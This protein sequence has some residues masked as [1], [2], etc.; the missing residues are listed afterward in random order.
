MATDKWLE[1]VQRLQS[2]AQSGLM[3]TEN[4]YDRERFKQIIDIAAEMGA[5]NSDD[6]VRTVKT[7]LQQEIGYITPKVDVRGAVF[8]DDGEVLLVKEARSGKWTLPGGWADVWDTPAQAVER[9]I[10]EESGYQTKAKQ[11]LAIYDRD[12]QGHPNSVLSIYKLYFLC[13]IVGG[14]A[15]TSH[16]TDAVEFFAEDN[17]PEIDT[18]R[19]LEKHLKR[20]FQQYREGIQTTDFD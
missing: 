6:D 13:E 7:F 5:Y 18:A 20:F 16:E 8:N 12:N 19:T 3:F 14:E 17:L 4:P 9:E 11:V 2:I 15:T 1:W 10:Y